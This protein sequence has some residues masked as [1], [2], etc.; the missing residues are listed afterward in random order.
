MFAIYHIIIGWFAKIIFGPP[1]VERATSRI[2]W[3]G[4]KS[5]HK[6]FRDQG[7][8]ELLNFEKLKQ[9]EQDRIFNELV[10]TNLLLFVLMLD[11]VAELTGGY[12]RDFCRDLSETLFYAYPRELAR[13]GVG[14][15]H[16]DLWNK[17]MKMRYDEYREDERRWKKR[18]DPRMQNPWRTVLA[19]GG[20]D[21]L[22]RGKTSPDDPLF[23]KMIEWLAESAMLM[24]TI[25]IRATRR[26]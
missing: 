4:L 21:H 10:V 25:L 3:S 18:P 26:L 8:R 5:A 11:T 23:P 12:R 15:E 16:V 22:R 7:V 13:M 14:E 19:V 9:T 17:L 2:M 24:E 1:S 20:L 6:F